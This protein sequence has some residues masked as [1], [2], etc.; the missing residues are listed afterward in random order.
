[1]EP[2]IEYLDLLTTSVLMWPSK[3]ITIGTIHDVPIPLEESDASI[4]AF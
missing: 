4:L 3:A 2:L 1:M